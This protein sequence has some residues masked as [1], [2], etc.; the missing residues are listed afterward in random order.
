MDPLNHTF[1]NTAI[2]KN[3]RTTHLLLECVKSLQYPK[4]VK[5]TD[6]ISYVCGF[7]LPFHLSVC[8]GVDN[9][10]G[11]IVAMTTGNIMGTFAMDQVCSCEL[12]VG[13]L[14]TS[15]DKRKQF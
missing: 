14:R 11:L 12:S 7:S 4:K 3:I 2:K 5:G 13:C 10:D 15:G 9:R 1:V 6:F 8:I